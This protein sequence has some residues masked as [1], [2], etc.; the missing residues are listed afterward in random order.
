MLERR[1]GA[2]PGPWP[3]AECSEFMDAFR[4]RVGVVGRESRPDGLR[5]G[6]RWPGDREARREDDWFSGRDASDR[7][8]A[9]FFW[10]PAVSND[11]WLRDCVSSLSS[12]FTGAA[13]V[14]VAVVV[15]TDSR[16]GGTGRAVVEAMM[17]CK[18]SWAL[19]VVRGLKL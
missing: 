19:G 14:V 15:L 16:R 18:R 4:S 13:V 10:S 12:S 5:E 1:E 6:M 7:R 3:L 8:R 17:L 9:P 2:R 11:S